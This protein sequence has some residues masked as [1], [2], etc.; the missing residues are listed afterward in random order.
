MNKLKNFTCLLML[1][2]TNAWGDIEPT[3]DFR[4]T[5]F[6]PYHAAPYYSYPYTTG[7]GYIFNQ[8]VVNAE[9]THNYND[10]DIV[11]YPDGP[12]EYNDYYKIGDTYCY[13]IANELVCRD[14]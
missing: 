1:L 12:Y 8:P 6:Y 14:Y 2:F 5:I 11:V 13:L 9:Y 3:D 7:Y 4:Q 10:Q